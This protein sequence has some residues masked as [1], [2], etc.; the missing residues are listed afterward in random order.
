M[1]IIVSV[2][3]RD[4][5]VLGSD[6]MTQ[7]YAKGSGGTVGVAQTYSNARKLF[8]VANGKVGVMTYGAG[9][10]ARR[11]L[12]GL[13]EDFNELIIKEAKTYD[14][15]KKIATKLSEELVKEYNLHLA[16]VKDEEKP[17]IGLFIGGYSEGSAFPEEWEFVLPKQLSPKQVRPI[18]A[19]GTSWRGVGLPFSRLYNGI[20]PRI[21]N[22][23]K[24]AGVD[25]KKI[26]EVI[27]K[28]RCQVAYDAMPLQDAV[29]FAHHILRTTVAYTT[30]EVGPP[31]CGGPFDIAVIT[32]GDGFKFVTSRTLSVQES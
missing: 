2:K 14:S 26:D 17:L 29:N 32:K 31:V 16:N 8:R 5:I 23:L 15:V 1:S 12:Q 18:D 25:E 28:Y 27:G 7:I 11:T 9:N 6:G 20:D 22:D 10:I 19:C 13:I 24:S 3:V 4:G 30:F 21:V